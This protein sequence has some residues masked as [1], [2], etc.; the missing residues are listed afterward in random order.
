MFPCIHVNSHHRWKLVCLTKT[1]SAIMYCICCACSWT[2]QCEFYAAELSVSSWRN[3]LFSTSPAANGAPRSG[4]CRMRPAECVMFFSTG[5]VRQLSNP[6][7]L[8]TAC[9]SGTELVVVSM[10]C[11]CVFS[12][13]AII[14]ESVNLPWMQMMDL[15]F[16]LNELLDKQANEI[17]NELH[18]KHL[19]ARDILLCLLKHS[20]GKAL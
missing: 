11:L 19:C 10:L 20:E 15:Q 7:W 4:M 2:S 3:Q 12:Y 1:C 17:N 16:K 8:Y 9:L 18:I 6:A 14:T 13:T 5:T